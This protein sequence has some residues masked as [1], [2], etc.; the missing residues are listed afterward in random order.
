MK[1]CKKLIALF[2]AFVMLVSVGVWQESSDSVAADTPEVTFSWKNAGTQDY[3]PLYRYLITLKIDG[4]SAIPASDSGNNTLYIDGKAV[5]HEGISYSS[6]GTD[7]TDGKPLIYLCLKFEALEEGA[8]SVAELTQSH[9]VVIKKGTVIR[10]MKLAEDFAFVLNKYTCTPLTSVSLKFASFVNQTN[11]DLNRYYIRLSV[12]GAATP[13]EKDSSI[14]NNNIVYVDGTAKTG[15]GVNY[16]DDESGYLIL[17]LRWDKVQD[18]VTN[19]AE[20][21]RHTV[22]I[23]EGTI[24]G[25]YM[26]VAEDCEMIVEKGNVSQPTPVKLQW[27]SGASQNNQTRYLITL[28]TGMTELG[29]GEDTTLTIDGKEVTHSGISYSSSAPAAADG[30]KQIYLCLQYG[31]LQEGA[32]SDEEITQ[33]RTIVIKK[34]TVI[35]GMVVAEDFAFTVNGS[36]VT[37]LTSVSMNLANYAHQDWDGLAR[38]FVNLSVAGATSPFKQNGVSLSKESLVYIDGA[39]STG[40]E[41]YDNTESGYLTMLVDYQDLEE[42]AVTKTDVGDHTLVVKQGTIIGGYMYVAETF[43]LHF[44]GAQVEQ[45]VST[46]EEDVSRVTLTPSK[47]TGYDEDG[48]YVVYAE[49]S[50]YLPG[51]IEQTVYKMTVNIGDT[52]CEVDG[53]KTDTGMLVFTIPAE[54]LSDTFTVTLPAGEYASADGNYGPIALD[55]FLLYV[56]SYG[57]HAKGYYESK[58]MDVELSLASGTSTAI[59]LT[60]TDT[61]T[62][63]GTGGKLTR[64]AEDGVSG[65]YYNGERTDVYLRKTA[66]DT[67]SVQLSGRSIT[68]VAGDNV[69]VTGAFT[70]DREYVDFATLSLTYNGSSWT[71][72][73]GAATLPQES[74][75]IVEDSFYVVPDHTVINDGAVTGATLSETGVYQLKTDIGGAICEREVVVYKQGDVTSDDKL[76]VMDLLMLKKHS[77]GLAELDKQGIAAGEIGL[78]GLRAMYVADEFDK[79]TKADEELPAGIIGQTGS[80][81][82]ITEV[83]ATSDGTTVFS[84]ADTDNGYTVPNDTYEGVGLDYVLDFNVD[85]DLKILQLTDPQLIDSSQMRSADRLGSSQIEMYKPENFEANAFSYIREAVAASNPDVIFVTGDLVY[86]EFDDNGSAFLALIE[87]MESLKIPWAPIFGNHDNESMMG[88]EWQC[89]QLMNAEYCLF[90]RRHSIGGNGNYSVGIAKNGSLERVMYLMDTHACWDAVDRSEPVENRVGFTEAQL[91]WYRALALHVG[92]FAGEEVPSFLCYHVPTTEVIKGGYVAGY[93]DIMENQ[94]TFSG[95]YQ[96]GVNNVAQPGDMGRHEERFKDAYECDSLLETMQEVGTDGAF[97]AHS[98]RNNISVKYGGVRWTFGLKTGTYDRYPTDLG[99]VLVTLP[100]GSD[101]F[102]VEQ[103][104]VK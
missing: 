51:I 89:E 7:E 4:V 27:A 49:P 92:S 56:N 71:V 39:A 95:S 70:T 97:F 18:G 69:I 34:G 46:A 57:Y 32:V 88:V 86:G 14:Y 102:T 73:T 33:Q 48:N 35:R 47:G 62:V 75:D 29:S 42:G 91:D 41:Y 83:E 20:V 25:G 104:V 17:L 63:T 65:V 21:T 55:E 82:Y 79:V 66:A 101:T 3:D 94:T 37:P 26:Y 103:I 19:S 31:V 8:G 24:I 90:N 67:W 50:D 40:I 13:F 28:Y 6:A 64:K 98:H 43:T 12:S 54:A 1:R 59:T 80:G 9:T 22:T 15:E 99:G 10:G 85:R 77:L 60:A 5:T 100:S 58:G 72:N 38:Y 61:M 44:T 68:A 76:D 2:M 36:T 16:Y 30:T 53:T 81:T 74:A 78:D 45:I 23:R 52:P 93:H 96:I 87:V 84:M 11:A